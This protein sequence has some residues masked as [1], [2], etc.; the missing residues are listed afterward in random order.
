MGAL[1]TETN[2]SVLKN[3][4]ERRIMTTEGKPAAGCR[5][6]CFL[7]LQGER[8][9]CFLSAGRMGVKLDPNIGIL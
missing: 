4:L 2:P 8:P 5:N 6:V 7:A 9:R 3:A 1:V